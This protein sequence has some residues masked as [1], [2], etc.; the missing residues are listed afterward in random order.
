MRELRR[1]RRT[2]AP[3]VIGATFLVTALMLPVS[4]AWGNEG[5]FGPLTYKNGEE[6]AEIDCYDVLN[7]EQ[8]E[9]CGSI[10]EDEPSWYV[11]SGRTVARHTISVTGNTSLLLCD[12]GELRMDGASLVVE[13]GATLDVYT[14]AG[15]TGILAGTGCERVIE[16]RGNATL[17]LHDG[18][19]LG[20]NGSSI[21]Y[22]GGKDEPAS[23]AQVNQYGGTISFGETGVYLDGG[24]F[25]MHDGCITDNA[26]AGVYATHGASCTVNDGAVY[27][28]EGYGLV[29]A[30][31]SD[32]KLAGGCVSYN[33][34]G[35][36]CEDAEGDGDEVGLYVESA[37][38]VDDNDDADVL[39]RKGQKITT[40]SLD[41]TASI[42]VKS[43]GDKGPITQGYRLN[44]Q[45]LDPRRVFASDEGLTPS[46]GSDGEVRLTAVDSKDGTGD[47]GDT[48]DESGIE[49]VDQTPGV[50]EV[51]GGEYAIDGP[52]DGDTGDAPTDAESV[53]SAD[54]EAKDVEAPAKKDQG[55]RGENPAE[56]SARKVT[57]KPPASK[58]VATEPEFVGSRVDY[59]S[60]IGFV[61]R[62]RL[63]QLEGVDWET[64]SMTF[65]VA[66]GEGRTTVIPY[67][68]ANVSEPGNGE[69]IASFTCKL[70][71][72]ELADEVKTAFSYEQGGKAKS[73]SRT[74][75]WE[76][77]YGNGSN[78]EGSQA[79][80]LAAATCDYGFYAQRFLSNR[81]GWALGGDHEAMGCCARTPDQ[82]DVDEVREELS[83][84]TIDKQLGNSAITNVAMSMRLGSTIT[85]DVDF[86]VPEGVEVH[87]HTNVDGRDVDTTRVND[88]LYRL[89]IEGLAAQQLA[90]PVIISGD[91]G[92]SF[93]LKVAPLY[94]AKQVLESQP[95]G[96]RGDVPMAALYNYHRAALECFGDR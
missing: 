14:Q 26:E 76:D 62:V 59:S 89:R 41:G 71:S 96:V 6:E 42:G 16:V 2:S 80:E 31:A 25:T 21:V 72:V 29:N 28:N 55:A 57:K 64:S 51:M 49:V 11:V 60:E 53:E 22:C 15:G 84:L 74:M 93:Y 54:G 86:T 92:G 10:D 88:T 73:V 30:G 5:A 63:P 40:G 38:I 82:M 35:V 43:E 33:K 47:E 87:G 45:K 69:K 17:N 8:S 7:E 32:F 3:K 44:N 20:S 23:N 91:A 90:T 65:K 77:A 81:K 36:A 50:T 19:F 70:S 66:G 79:S 9:I 85:V 37:P 61:A 39:L 52:S 12:D 68:E 83:Q 94:Y 67:G 75:T 1:G 48:G 78:A 56:S 95:F 27:D 58:P 18:N 13:P 46:C 24:S 34:V 4:Y